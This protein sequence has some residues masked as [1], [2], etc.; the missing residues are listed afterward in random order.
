M[1]WH[2]SICIPDR[3]DRNE[4]LSNKVRSELAEFDKEKDLNEKAKEAVDI[5]HSA[6]NLVRK[7]F[8]KHPKLSFEKIKTAVVSK[9]AKRG[10]Y[11]RRKP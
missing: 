8:N 4:R 10:Y 9:N 1:K 6:E 11:K 5:L 2:F 7:F 3:K